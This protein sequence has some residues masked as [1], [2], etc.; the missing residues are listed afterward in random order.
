M[1]KTRACHTSVTRLPHAVFEFQ[2]HALNARRLLPQKSRYDVDGVRLTEIILTP[3]ITAITFRRDTS[4]SCTARAQ[5]GVRPAGIPAKRALHCNGAESPSLMTVFL[6][7]STNMQ[8]VRLLYRP[9]NHKVDLHVYR[10]ARNLLVSSNQD[11]SQAQNSRIV[12]L[13]VPT[14][15]GHICRGDVAGEADADLPQGRCYQAGLIGACILT[16]AHDELT[17]VGISRPTY[18]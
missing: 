7:S 4:P 10:G 5:L 6:I 2:H 13:D 11:N 15:S 3:A 17:A 14:V 9:L 1:S 12:P 8:P 18:I 16:T